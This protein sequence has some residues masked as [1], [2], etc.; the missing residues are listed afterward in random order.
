MKG[1]VYLKDKEG[2]VV[3]VKDGEPLWTSGTLMQSDYDITVN[4]ASARQTYRL[5]D[6]ITVSKCNFY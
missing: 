1:A 3:Y 6:H 5:F 2:Q 4:T